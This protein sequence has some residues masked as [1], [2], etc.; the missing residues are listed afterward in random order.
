MDRVLSCPASQAGSRGGRRVCN[1]GGEVFDAVSFTS[2]EL[3]TFDDFAPAVRHFCAPPSRA[4]AERGDDAAGV[5]SLRGDRRAVSGASQRRVGARL[6]GHAG[7]GEGVSDAR[8]RRRDSLGPLRGGLS[9]A[10]VALGSDRVSWRL[11]RRALRPRRPGALRGSPAPSPRGG[12]ARAGD[13]FGRRSWGR[14]HRVSRALSRGALPRSRRGDRRRARG[15]R[16]VEPGLPLPAGARADGV[17]RRCESARG[18]VRGGL[19]GGCV[20]DR[21]LRHA[22]VGRRRGAPAAPLQQRRIAAPEQRAPVR[23][24]VLEDRRHVPMPDG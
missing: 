11:R 13:D 10:R 7:I 9:R 6:L 12:G 15:S 20:P 21:G 18:S 8:G 14:S 1:V 5:R 23:A 22:C 16:A 17:L 19:V 3:R 2:V 24:R 4:R